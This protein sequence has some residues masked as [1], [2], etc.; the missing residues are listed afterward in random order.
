[1]LCICHLVAILTDRPQA[2]ARLATDWR[3]NR[4]GDLADRLPAIV[5]D[6]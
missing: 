3:C 4:R 2:V 1:L 5:M 6:A